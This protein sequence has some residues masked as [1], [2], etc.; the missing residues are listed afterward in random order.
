MLTTVIVHT[1]ARNMPC[2]DMAV[3]GMELCLQHQEG[4]VWRIWRVGGGSGGGGGGGGRWW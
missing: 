3:H 2:Y 4:G 1:R